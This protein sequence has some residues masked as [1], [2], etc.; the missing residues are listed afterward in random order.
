MDS[1]DFGE[2]DPCQWHTAHQV[3]SGHLLQA[4]RNLRRKVTSNTGANRGRTWGKCWE[5]RVD[6]GKKTVDYWKKKASPLFS[7][8]EKKLKTLEKVK[9]RICTL[10][11]FTAEISYLYNMCKVWALKHAIAWYL[12]RFG[13]EYLNFM[14]SWNLLFVQYVQGFGT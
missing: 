13:L 9:I 11:V 14:C 7:T 12:K 8:L 6:T 2:N 1:I 5:N 4:G 10:N 3:S